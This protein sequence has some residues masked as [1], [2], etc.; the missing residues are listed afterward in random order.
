[1][2]LNILLILTILLLISYIIFIHEQNSCSDGYTTCVKKNND[3][4]FLLNSIDG[5]WISNDDFNK[6]SEID[7]MTLYIDFNTYN[8]DL[9]IIIN[10]K[11]ISNDKYNIYID[12]ENI[13]KDRDILKFKISFSN[14]NKNTIWNNKNFTCL[15]SPLKGGFQLYDENNIIYG[16]FLKDNVISN[17]INS[18]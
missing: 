10:N 13:S 5:Y 1:M 8:A 11:I 2:G 17:F 3:S 4:Q 16:D 15:L 7:K 18:L 12:D 9:V 14:S 6:E